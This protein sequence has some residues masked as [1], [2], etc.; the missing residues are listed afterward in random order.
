VGS[1]RAGEPGAA[2]TVRLVRPDRQLDQLLK[3]FEGSRASS[4]AAALASWKQAAHG[5]AKLSKSTEAL[6]ALLNPEMV[7]ELRVVDGAWGTLGFEPIDGKAAWRVTVPHDDGT[8]AA[9]VTAL[10]LSGGESLPVPKGASSLQRL[11]PP[12]SSVMAQTA[13]A[14]VA[15]ANT[16]DGLIAWGPNAVAPISRPDGLDSGFTIRL[17]PEGLKDAG[18]LWCRAISEALRADGC[19]TVE[20]VAVLE[21][22][23]ASIA[24][25]TRRE[26]A[27]RPSLTRTVP[28]DWLDW[29]PAATSLVVAAWPIDPRPEAW[30]AW[31]ALAD[32][33]ERVDP[34]KAE[35]APL[36]VR[37]NLL[38]AAAR[39][40][41]EVD[42]WP[43]LRGI[44]GGIL[45][46]PQFHL[47]GAWVAL[48]ADSAPAAQQI[49]GVLIPRLA[50]TR[51]ADK[52]AENPEPGN[53]TIRAVGRV[54]GKPL[55][56]L[57][58]G[59]TVL[60]GW[61]EGVLASCVE[62]RANPAQS[63]G[64][65]VRE[66][67]GATPLQ[68]AGAFWPGRLPL[69]ALSGA[70]PARWQHRDDGAVLRDDVRWSGLRGIVHEYLE[71]LLPQGGQPGRRRE[72]PN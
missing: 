38:A 50:G 21:G 55:T 20:G 51:T 13:G 43:H 8:V 63:A 10:T 58:Q 54:S 59:Q 48:H 22:D 26:P 6:I 23:A 7:S 16:K 11:G 3:L 28:P 17:D 29:A 52:L 24:L 69:L 61:G 70:P 9:L 40:R 34:A 5:R 65:A 32:R 56:V 14:Q 64:S 66:C 71:R 1:A 2:V 15:I 35:V 36:R 25:T 45:I 62:A 42:L 60:V 4:P 47:A 12:G 18:P 19:R 30:N 39:V 46:D 31:F 49:G 37:L 44:S 68:A 72:S 27:K 67:W 53:N 41:P 33:V 57:A